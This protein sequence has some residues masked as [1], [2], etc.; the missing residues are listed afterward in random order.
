MATAADI[1]GV[2]RNG[3]IPARWS[4]HYDQLCAERDRLEARD[5]SAPET[6]RTKLDDL[7]E[8]ASD[9]SEANISLVATSATQDTIFEVLTALGRI[10]RGT[11]GICELTGDPIEAERLKAI[12]WAR[13]SLLRQSELEKAGEVRRHAVP[14]LEALNEVILAEGDEAA[15]EETE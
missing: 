9:E 15:T 14:R 1:L 4:Q 2:Y 10:E 6:C 5:C 8:G 3:K 12:P 7:T 13:Y 11:Y